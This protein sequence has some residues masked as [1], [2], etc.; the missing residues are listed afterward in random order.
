MAVVNVEGKE[1]AA[2]EERKKGKEQLKQ[3]EKH[4]KAEEVISIELL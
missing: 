4:S 1:N 2:E 3:K